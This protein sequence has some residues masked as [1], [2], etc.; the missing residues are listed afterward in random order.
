M[1]RK[2]TPIFL[3]FLTATYNAQ[4]DPIPAITTQS[5]ATVYSFVTTQDWLPTHRL[6]LTATGI[7]NALAGNEI[8]M[9]PAGVITFDVDSP[10]PNVGGVRELVYNYAEGA[11]LVSLVISDQPSLAVNRWIQLARPTVQNGF[12][13]PTPPATVYSDRRLSD[14]GGFLASPIPAGT[15][16]Y[17]T[18]AD[19]FHGDNSGAFTIVSSS[20]VGVPEPTELAASLTA[21][22][23]TVALAKKR[24]I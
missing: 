13:S 6:T 5:D 21:L 17:L 22:A 4:A 2:I 14:Y 15:T 20:L 8:A 3:L 10:M 23:A 1:F 11:H 16:L 9:N 18:V 19:F 12:G 7:V 24:R